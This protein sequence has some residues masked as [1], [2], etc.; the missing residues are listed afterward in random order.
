[1][2]IRVGLFTKPQGVPYLEPDWFTHESDA[3]EPIDALEEVQGDIPVAWIILVQSGRAYVLA[4]DVDKST[5]DPFFD[6]REQDA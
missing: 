5:D 3:A 4:W 6:S 1:M 2:R